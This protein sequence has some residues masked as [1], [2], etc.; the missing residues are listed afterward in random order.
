MLEG[1]L[2]RRLRA[3]DL[4]DFRSYVDLLEDPARGQG[5]LQDLID[6]VTTNQTAFWR[7]PQQLEF[8]LHEGVAQLAAATGAG[9]RRQLRAWSAACSSGEEPYCLAMILAERARDGSL[10]RG[11]SVLATDI[12]HAMLARA[13][14]AVYP[15]DAAEPLPP[16]LHARYLMRARDRRL[17]V[18]RIA[19][20]IRAAVRFGR[21]NLI[22][23]AFHV[24][25]PVRPRALPQRPDLLR[26]RRAGAHPGQA[27]P[28][29][30]RGRPALPRARRQHHGPAP[31]AAA[32]CARTPT[33]GSRGT[34]LRKVRVLIVDDSASVRTALAAIV[35]R[36]ADLE[37]VGTA[38][39]PYFAPT[40]SAPTRPT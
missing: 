9:T 28:P 2:R 3:L 29:P 1:R 17:G 33:C 37:L 34:T 19:P 10:P 13:R 4:A 8:L 15:A 39:D 25:E 30:A 5:E 21:L 14:R 18:V 16:D 26:R 32:S 36:E 23:S 24:G 22:D 27:L 35:E 31:A 38:S 6:C 20:E 11:S 40:R 7:E 12:S